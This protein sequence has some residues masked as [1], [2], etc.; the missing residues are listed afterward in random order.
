[1]DK[2]DGGFAFPFEQKCPEDGQM[3]HSPGMTLRDYFAAKIAP[4]FVEKLGQ[5]NQDGTVFTSQSVSDWAYS[6]ADAMLEARK[7]GAK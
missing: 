1:M 2:N 4:A 7:G 6:I 3:W 5:V